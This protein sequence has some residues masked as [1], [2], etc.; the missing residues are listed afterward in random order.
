MNDFNQVS[1]LA[2]LFNASVEK[3]ELITDRTLEVHKNTKTYGGVQ[4]VAEDLINQM[5][6]LKKAGLFLLDKCRELSRNSRS[7]EVLSE[8]R[9]L[10]INFKNGSEELN[11]NIALLQQC[12]TRH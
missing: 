8:L 5:C 9:R 12:V 7:E 2:H 11:K 3:Y 10:S 6:E 4:D 1:N